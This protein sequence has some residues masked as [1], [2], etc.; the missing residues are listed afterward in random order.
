[1]C[2]YICDNQN[3]H[4]KTKNTKITVAALWTKPPLDSCFV[5][6]ALCKTNKLSLSNMSTINNTYVNTTPDE[7]TCC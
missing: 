7:Q 2:V 6:R 1:M 3:V 4:M 5:F